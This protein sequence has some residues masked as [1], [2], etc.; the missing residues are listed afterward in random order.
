MFEKSNEIKQYCIV[1]CLYDCNFY[2]DRNLLRKTRDSRNSVFYFFEICALI[3]IIFVQTFD[4]FLVVTFSSIFF[5]LIRY[6]SI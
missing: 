5:N 6:V 4:W 1:I 3:I 2:S